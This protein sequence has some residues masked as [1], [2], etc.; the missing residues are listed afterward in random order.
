MQLTEVL[1]TLLVS[2]RMVLLTTSLMILLTI[3]V[4]M[5]HLTILP[6]TLLMPPEEIADNL[7]DNLAD[8]ISQV[9]CC[10]CCCCRQS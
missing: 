8:T 2:S 10:C 1:S 6:A 5:P 4:M 9:S 7:A 3:S